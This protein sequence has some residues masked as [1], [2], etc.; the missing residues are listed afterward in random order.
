[1]ILCPQAHAQCRRQFLYYLSNAVH[2]L[3]PSPYS[4]EKEG[5]MEADE[6]PCNMM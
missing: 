6:R 4:A 5:Q 1:M 2:Y 3:D